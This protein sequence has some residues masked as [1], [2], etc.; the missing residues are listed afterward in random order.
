MGVLLRFCMEDFCGMFFFVS[1]LVREDRVGVLMLFI[2]YWENFLEV[3]RVLVGI[4][5]FVIN[6]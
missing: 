5:K 2:E 3:L 6:F 4:C 1:V